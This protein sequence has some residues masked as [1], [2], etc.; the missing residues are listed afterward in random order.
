[1]QCKCLFVNN[2]TVVECPYINKQNWCKDITICPGNDDSWCYRAIR[3]AHEAKILLEDLKNHI[4]KANVL[5][6]S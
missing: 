5:N 2:F 1:M 3:Y 6:D 4:A